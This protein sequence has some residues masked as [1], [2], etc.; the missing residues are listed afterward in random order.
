MNA[1]ELGA[2]NATSREGNKNQTSLLG[3]L[4]SQAGQGASTAAM[5][6]DER[7]KTDVID[8]GAQIDKMLDGLHAKAGRYKD[9]KHG[10]GE[11]NWIMA[12]DMERSQAGKRVV[13]EAPDGSKMLDVNKAVSTSLAAAARLNERLRKLEASRR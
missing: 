9:E 11:W 10:K 1:N 5:M 2:A 13:F 3:G 4:L 6:S 12:Q 7:L 8:A